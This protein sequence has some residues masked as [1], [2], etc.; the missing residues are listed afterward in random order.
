MDLTIAI[1]ALVATVAA[2]VAAVGSWRAATKANETTTKVSSI[3]RDRRHE[4]LTPKFQITCGEKAGVPVMADLHLMLTAGGI[5]HLDE[6]TVTILDETDS[7]HWGPGLPLGVSQE[8][9]AA[10][11][12]GPWAASSGI[13]QITMN[14]GNSPL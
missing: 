14:W 6:V 2:S 1:I 9:A 10:F 3:E 5:E 8:Q 4:E 11:V 13:I 12:W 7:N